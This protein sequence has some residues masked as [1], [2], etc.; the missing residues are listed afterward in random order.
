MSIDHLRQA[1]QRKGNETRD[2]ASRTGSGTKLL[3]T[4]FVLL[5]GRAVR[6]IRTPGGLVQYVFEEPRKPDGGEMPRCPAKP[7]PPI[8]KS[9][10][11]GYDNK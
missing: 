1:P 10:T 7:D 4:D 5:P 3:L 8:D 9:Q 2:C 6:R 11:A